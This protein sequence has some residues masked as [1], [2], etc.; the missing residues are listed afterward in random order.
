MGWTAASG[1]PGW[2]RWPSWW[3][4]GRTR[5]AVGSSRSCGTAGS[6]RPGSRRAEHHRCRWSTRWWPPPRRCCPSRDRARGAAG[7]GRRGV[8]RSRLGQHRLGGGHKH[9]DD[10]H[11]WCA[12]RREAGRREPAV[13]HDREI[14]AAASS[15]AGGHERDGG[16][17]SQP[18]AA[19]QHPTRAASGPG[20]RRPVRNVPRRRA[21]SAD[22]SHAKRVDGRP[23]TSPVMTRRRVLIDGLAA[24]ARRGATVRSRRARTAGRRGERRR[25]ENR[26][27]GPLLRASTALGRA[28]GC[29]TG[30]RAVTGGAYDG[31]RGK[32]SSGAPPTTRRDGLRSAGCTRRCA[33]SRRNSLTSASRACA[34]V[35]ES[36]GGQ[37][38]HL[39]ERP[40]G[41]AAGEVRR[42]RRAG[43]ARSPRRA[44]R[45]WGRGTGRRRGR[46]AD[47]GQGA[48][49]AL[50]GETSGQ[51]VEQFL[52][53]CTPSEPSRSNRACSTST[54]ALASVERAVIGCCVAEA[55]VPRRQPKLGASSL[56]STR[57]ASRTVSDDRGPRARAAE[58]AAGGL[59]KPDVEARVVRDQHGPRMNSRNEGSTVARSAR[60]YTIASVIPVSMTISAGC[61]ARV[62]QGGELAENL[63]ARSP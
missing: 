41:L 8:A 57:L 44:P 30:E 7:G 1:W 42:T 31:E 24:G 59:D 32:G 34:Q 48:L 47:L 22:R 25:C 55:A 14:P 36:S 11:R 5:R 10:R 3:P 20:R 12:A 62:D 29:G 27:A 16:Q 56:V 4:P 49:A 63:A 46:S 52:R 28:C 2:P 45:R 43:C 15:G 38:D 23:A 58:R 21:A 9:V 33:A 35:T 13:P 18:L 54:V 19:V 39:A 60:V 51:V 61:P 50:S 6:R 53:D 17:S 37:R 26:P 40:P